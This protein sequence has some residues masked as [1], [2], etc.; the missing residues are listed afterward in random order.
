MVAR[1]DKSAVHRLALALVWLAVALS[2]VVFSEPAPVDVLMAGVI[3]LLPVI[4]LIRIPPALLVF[5]S[6]WLVAGLSSFV[7]VAA[8][9]EPTKAIVHNAVGIFLYLGSFVLAGFVIARPLQHTR[10]IYSAYGVAALIA[11]LAGIAG[12]FGL[13]PGASDLLTKFGRARGTFKDPNVFG[14]FLVPALLYAVSRIVHKP[15]WAIA[16]PLIGFGVLGFALLL[17]FSRGAWLCFAI[18]LSVYGYLLFVT[19]RTNWLR[20]RLMSFALFG[21]VLGFLAIAGALRSDKIGDLLMQRA[22]VTQ[23]YDEGPEGRFGGQQKAKRLILTNPFGIGAQQFAPHYHLEEPHNAYLAVFLNAG[24]IGGLIFTGMMAL[25]T[26]VGLRH[27]FRR[28]A[29]QPLFLV[30]YAA[31]VGHVAEA[32]VIDLDHWRHLYLLMAIIWGLFLGD[33]E[34]ERHTEI[35]M[36]HPS[37]MTVGE[38]TRA[39]RL[40]RASADPPPSRPRTIV[41]RRKAAIPRRRK[42][43]RSPRIARTW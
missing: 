32:F 36:P 6:I 16:P 7:A 43:R 40:M 27:A 26:L 37:A 28:T 39:P 15:L 22:A 42:I 31:F 12:Y 30:A 9:I 41:R 18:A 14:P 33:R 17:S 23:G 1:D 2:G 21:V 4:G 13:I 38:P 24:W 29:T 5:L 34:L 20:V 10:L 19:A 8:A 11:A 3:G 35:R 25:T